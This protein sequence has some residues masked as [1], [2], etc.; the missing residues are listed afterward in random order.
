MVVR[1][2]TLI[3]TAF[4]TIAHRT[5]PVSAGASPAKWEH[6]PE[7]SEAESRERVGGVKD[8]G[9]FGEFH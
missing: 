4:P 5:E 7:N 3:K 9:N 8:D 6:R 2:C 1:T